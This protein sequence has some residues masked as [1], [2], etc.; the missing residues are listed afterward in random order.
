MSFFERSDL[1]YYYALADAFTFGDHYHQSTFTCTCPNREHFFSGSNG[2]SVQDT[3]PGYCEMENDEPDPGFPWETMAE[4]LMKANVTWR[5]FQEQDNFD[6]NGFAWFESFHKALPGTPL[7][8]NGLYRSM[9]LVAEFAKAVETDTLP[10]VSWI[11]GPAALSEHATNHPADG[12]DLSARLLKILGDPAN[13]AV[14]AKTAF[15]LNYDEGGQFFDHLW[16]PTPPIDET[17]GAST[18]T[19]HG[20]LTIAENM[21]VAAGNP[22]GLGFRVPFFVISPWT[23]GGYVYS[24]VCDHTSVIKFIEKRF[25]VHCPNISPWRRAMV[26]HA[27]SRCYY[28]DDYDCYD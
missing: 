15:I 18:V 27:N 28:Y 14:F 2:L 8:D 16:A 22:I 9:D 1:P 12:E 26:R 4:T 11:V 7:W 13:Q 10:Q 6:D 20:E 23:R 21:G 24:E 19:T 17:D 3:F 5:V 25:G